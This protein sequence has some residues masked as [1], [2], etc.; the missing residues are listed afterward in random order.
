MAV[1]VRGVREITGKVAMRWRLHNLHTPRAGECDG[2]VI[3][4]FWATFTPSAMGITRSE[5]HSNTQQLYNSFHYTT[6]HP[7]QPDPDKW[8]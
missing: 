8:S 4:T 6:A 5:R 2:N 1:I 3:V 7:G